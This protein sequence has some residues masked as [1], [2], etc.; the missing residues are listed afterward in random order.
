MKN[1][2]FSITLALIS[3]APALANLNGSGFYRVKN[4]GT[5]RWAYMVDNK[6]KTDIHATQIEMHSLQLS[7]NTDSILGAPGSVVYISP[8]SGMEYNVSAQGTNL[9]QLTGYSV[10]LGPDGSANGQALYQIFG[11]YKGVTEYIGDK[12]AILSDTWGTA[13]TQGVSQIK[14]RQWFIIPVSADSDNFFGV[15]P[16]VSAGG[17]LYNA[18]YTSFAYQPVSSSV[19]AYYISRVGNGMAEMIAI[20]GAVPGGAPVIVECAGSTAADNKMNLLTSASALPSNALTGVY[21]DW[22]NEGWVNEVVYDP[23]TMRVLGQCSDGSLGFITSSTLKTI[24]ANSAYLKVAAGSP[25]EY[26]CVDSATFTAGVDSVITDSAELSYKNGIVS[27]GGSGQ[28]SIVNMSGQVVARNGASIDIS[29]L[30]KG[31]YIA[32]AGGKRLKVMVN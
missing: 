6:A 8:V 25:A 30:P 16:T 9:A 17:K 4:Y 3:F 21:F 12:N 31:V 32:M 18:T 22:N 11:T 2:I 27:Y 15:V 7:N 29:T 13:T 20:S 26:K 5:N 28:I 1:L 10:K 14:F 19:K 24:P 23:A